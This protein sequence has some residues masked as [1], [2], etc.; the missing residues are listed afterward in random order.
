ML[1][2]VTPYL[3]NIGDLTLDD[4]L[5]VTD[6]LAHDAVLVRPVFECVKLYA[7]LDENSNL[8]Y[9]RHTDD[10]LGTNRED[11]IQRMSDSSVTEA[12][13]AAF[14][15]MEETLPAIWPFRPG[16][17]SWC[18]LEIL[19]PRIM[20]A[21]SENPSKIIIR[22][23][24][25]IDIKGNKTK[26]Q[27]LDRMFRTFTSRIIENSFEAYIIDP[28]VYLRNASGTG[29]YTTLKSEIFE[30]CKSSGFENPSISDLS[31]INRQTLVEIMK[32]FT[33]GLFLANS[34]T[35]LSE[36]AVGDDLQ[37]C[38]ET[39]PGIN[40]DIEGLSFR[41]SGSFLARKRSI[42]AESNKT[43]KRLLPLPPARRL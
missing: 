29:I 39:F 30:I 38:L 28:K 27:L 9:A 17:S 25:R 4:V 31:L 33:D 24:V 32:D 23:A 10:F 42:I 34:H 2:S 22:E 40:V 35:I 5:E 3:W 16:S 15:Y 8:R 37:F 18:L 14:D 41:L 11:V 20:I 36:S 7:K 19:D 13:N 26:T 1:F 43:K 6:K 12:L 21:G